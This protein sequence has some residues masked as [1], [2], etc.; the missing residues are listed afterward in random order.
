MKSIW[1]ICARTPSTVIDNAPFEIRWSNFYLNF[2]WKKQIIQNDIFDID[3]GIRLASHQ[4]PLKFYLFGWHH[5]KCVL[6]G[7]DKLGEHR[8]KIVSKLTG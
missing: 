2:T 6:P 3:T 4:L 7:Y 5:W 8:L 1:I